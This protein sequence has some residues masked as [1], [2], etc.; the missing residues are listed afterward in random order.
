MER[1]ELFGGNQWEFISEAAPFNFRRHF[2]LSVP[3]GVVEIPKEKSLTRSIGGII[4]QAISSRDVSSRLWWTGG[5]AEL[6]A[7]AGLRP[8]TSAEN[9]QWCRPKGN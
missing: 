2:K 5:T 3:S 1:A 7:T 6:G 4:V 9:C 8:R